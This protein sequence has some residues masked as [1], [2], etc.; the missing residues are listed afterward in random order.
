M[1]CCFVYANLQGTLFGRVL[2]GMNLIRIVL[3]LRERSFNGKT[4]G[5]LF[6]LFIR[7]ANLEFV[8]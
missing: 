6:R 1:D 7:R 2:S 5:I 3:F 8:N 4:M